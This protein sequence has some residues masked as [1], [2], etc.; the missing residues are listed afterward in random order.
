[1]QHR[2]PCG[3]LSRRQFLA[4]SAASVPLISGVPVLAAPEGA[5]G[6]TTHQGGEGKALSKL[7]APGLYPGRVIEVQNPAD[8]PQRDQ[9]SGGNQGD[10][11]RAA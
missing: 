11:R 2:Y 9:G 5:P 10:P 8:D 3:S 1:M 4:A 6:K 7:A